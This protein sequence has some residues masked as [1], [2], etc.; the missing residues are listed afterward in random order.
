[1]F[2]DCLSAFDSRDRSASGVGPPMVL[3][4]RL[5]PLPLTPQGQR[6]SPFRQPGLRL[7]ECCGVSSSSEP[8]LPTLAH[9]VPR[10]GAPEIKHE[11]TIRSS[12]GATPTG[13]APHRTRPRLDRPVPDERRSI[14]A[15][16]D[17][18]GDDRRRG[19]DTQSRRCLGRPPPPQSIA[20]RGLGNARWDI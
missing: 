10:Y 7:S 18:V 3:C 16:S 13:S 1:M 19:I 4:G 14:A 8:C 20:R 17:H 15:A 2:R 6:P 11:T 12:A 9:A 5:V